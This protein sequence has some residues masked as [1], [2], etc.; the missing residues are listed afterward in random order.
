LI[1]DQHSNGLITKKKILDAA[2]KAELT[3]SES[4][5]KQIFSIHGDQ[6]QYITF[7]DFMI[8]NVSQA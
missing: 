8:A 7:D 1:L 3:L 2:K 4:E 5:I 6:H